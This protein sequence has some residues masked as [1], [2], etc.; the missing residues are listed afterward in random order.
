MRLAQ[1]NRIQSE[2]GC[3]LI[4]YVICKRKIH[5]FGP[6]WTNRCQIEDTKF[7][8]CSILSSWSVYC[9]T[10]MLFY[11]MIG[12]VVRWRMQRIKGEIKWVLEKI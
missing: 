10:R 8:L 2:N 9:F 4:V 11:G 1:K 5:I 12:G 6:F 7:Y 3:W